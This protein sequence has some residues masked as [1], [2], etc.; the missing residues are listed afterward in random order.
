MKDSGKK[1]KPGGSLFLADRLRRRAQQEIA[2]G[3]LKAAVRL[4]GRAKKIQPDVAHFAQL[5]AATLAEL[6]LSARRSEGCGRKAQASKAKK[7]LSVVSCGFGPPAQMTCE[8]VDAMRSCGAV[9]SCCLDAIAARGVFK[10][11]IP[12]VRCRFQSLSRNIRRAFV[13]H[14]NVG[15]LIYGNPLFLNPH[16]EGILRDI[17]SLAEVQVL[18]GISSFD[19]LV[20]MFGMMNLSGKG[21][22]LAD[23]ES[24]VK[25]PQFEP[26]QDTFFFSPW[27]INDKENRRYRA[28]FFKAIADK[29]PGRFP[30]FLAK[31]S[32]NPAKCEIIRGC[33]ACLPSL[34]KYCDRAHT[35]VVFSERGQLSLSNSPP[36]LRLE[37]RNKCVCD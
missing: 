9:Y 6:N 30:V 34:L 24:V 22:Y 19:A 29:Y 12:L 32:L 27:R 3:D 35:L 10:L 17:S 31:Y 14:D 5:Y 4:L 7:K 28:G 20:N 1:D 33:V 11:S 18:P 37:V 13:R 26:E 16:V 21:V 25:D 8:S 23:C 2:K 36:W 15:L